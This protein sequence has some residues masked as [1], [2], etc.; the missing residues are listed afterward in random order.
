MEAGGH[1]VMDHGGMTEVV[2]WRMARDGSLSRARNSW[3]VVKMGE[4]QVG[5]GLR[6]LCWPSLAVVGQCG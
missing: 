5:V 4:K 1:R 2:T 6:G 3:R